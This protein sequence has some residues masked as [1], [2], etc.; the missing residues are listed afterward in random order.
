MAEGA[1]LCAP[2]CDALRR[3][4]RRVFTEP[5]LLE[6]LSH[7]ARRIGRPYAAP[8]IAAAIDRDYLHRA[9]A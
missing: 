2:T 9:A 6:G 1:A 8:A 4:L 3:E 7:A 5:G